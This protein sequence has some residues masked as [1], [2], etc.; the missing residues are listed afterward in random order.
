MLNMIFFIAPWFDADFKCF[1]YHVK[2]FL[3]SYPHSR[4][5]YVLMSPI[6]R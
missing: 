4:S 3:W 6:S 5:T 1:I 2:M